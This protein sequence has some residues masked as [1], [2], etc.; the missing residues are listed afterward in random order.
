[1]F[2]DLSSLISPNQT[3]AVAVSGGS[4]SV[5][6]LHYIHNASKIYSFSVIAIN[7]EHGIRGES[8]VSDSIFVKNLCEK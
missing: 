6:L 2:I 4:D 7:V 1:M 8:S 5:A 3:V